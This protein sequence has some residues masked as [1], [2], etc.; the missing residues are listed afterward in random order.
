MLRILAEDELRDPFFRQS[1]KQIL[2]DR[3]IPVF[4]YGI[5][6]EKFHL[7]V[8]LDTQRDTYRLSF[9]KDDVGTVHA[10]KGEIGIRE[11]FQDV[12][13]VSAD[14]VFQE[15]IVFS[16]SHQIVDL[17][18]RSRHAV[19]EM[20][21]DEDQ[22]EIHDCRRIGA[23]DQRIDHEDQAADRVDDP[24]LDDGYHEEG[25]QDKK[26]AKIAYGFDNDFTV[27]L[28]DLRLR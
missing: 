27:H 5:I 18:V 14:E 2:A 13:L 8:F 22:A 25:Y 3:E 7:S 6:Q 16:D 28:Y 12:F 17:G 24:E 23:D 21:I 10:F 1:R 9:V 4:R 20:K 26:R 19:E 15:R 11:V